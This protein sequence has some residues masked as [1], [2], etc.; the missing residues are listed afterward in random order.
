MSLIPALVLG[1]TTLAGAAAVPAPDVALGIA[2]YDRGDF[3]TALAILKP[4]VY[5]VPG[6]WLDP[7]Y[8]WAGAYLAQMF[9]RGQGTAPDW[10]LSCALFNN[11]WAYQHQQSPGSADAAIPFVADGIKEV[12]LSDQEEV[13]ALRASCFLD[14]VTRRDF[15]LD[16]GALVV[17]DRRGFHL[18]LAGQ[19]RDVGLSMTCHD[20]LV[21]LTEAD[22]S[23]PDR[24]SNRRVHFLELFK[25][26][27]GAR[28]GRV[29]RE[30]H[31]I[32]YVVRGV[33]LGVVTDQVIWTVTDGPYPSTEMPFGVREAT[34]LRVN[35]AGEVEWIVKGSPEKRGVIPK[36]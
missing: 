1:A 29:V 35:A 36:P 33:D 17:V 28:D 11:V 24:S 32:V 31:W 16:G 9:R 18:D 4:I 19:H 5:D 15:V 20:V 26:R 27:S 23:I 25:W 3:T 2:A 10:P 6:D 12:C 7:R 30:L 14:G 34:I 13:T 8:A 21:S 22:V